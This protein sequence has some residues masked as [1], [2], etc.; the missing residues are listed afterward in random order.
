MSL[1][2]FYEI[3][4]KASKVLDRNSYRDFERWISG[5][6]ASTRDQALAAYARRSLAQLRYQFN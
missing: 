6:I 5:I 1:L 2:A 3:K 4:E